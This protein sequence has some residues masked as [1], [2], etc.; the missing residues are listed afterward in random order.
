[1][2]T[3]L[4]YWQEACSQLIPAAAQALTAQFPL[5]VVPAA[6]QEPSLEAF[7]TARFQYDAAWLLRELPQSKHPHESETPLALWL[8]KEDISYSGHDYLHGAAW[9]NLALVS[10][11]R[12]GSAEN[13]HKELCHEAGHLFGLEHCSRPCLMNG[14][15]SQRQLN[16]KPL[17]L[18]IECSSI[19]AS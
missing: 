1:M 18:C 19:L 15:S 7:D 8:I 2:K 16:A 6:V 13:L 5:T 3:L 14:S 4:L 9:R 17:H 10:T 11:A 12:L